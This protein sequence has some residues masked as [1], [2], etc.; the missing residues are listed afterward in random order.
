MENIEKAMQ[1]LDAIGREVFRRT[2]IPVEAF[3]QLLVSRPELVLRNVF[4]LFHDMIK[5][6][7]GEPIDEYASDPESIHYSFYDSS[8]LF[9][10]GVD[11]PFQNVTWLQNK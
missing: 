1:H 11:N 8:R 10:D 3:L 9:V 4:Q 6:Y 7:V 5:S 2:P